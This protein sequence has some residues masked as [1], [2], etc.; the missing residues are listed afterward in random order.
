MECEGISLKQAFS[1]KPVNRKRK[2]GEGIWMDPGLKG[3]VAWGP[4]G[5]R[6][7]KHVDQY[8]WMEMSA[9]YS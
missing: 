6:G 9:E 7:D 8:P 1:L 5:G 2:C 4:A 3:K